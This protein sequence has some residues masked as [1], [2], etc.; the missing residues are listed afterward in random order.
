MRN[1][2]RFRNV[3]SGFVFYLHMTRQ[4]VADC[5]DSSPLT[6][7]YMIHELLATN[8]ESPTTGRLP[9]LSTFLGFRTGT[10]QHLQEVGGASAHA[11]VNVGFTGFDV[12]VEVVAESLDVRDDF[13]A[14]GGCEVAREEDW[15][16]MLARR[17]SWS[18]IGGRK[19]YQK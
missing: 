12:V 11:A 17:D 5:T 18:G 14:A 6:D 3:E 15:R 19:A 16:G 10:T 13:F 9:F 1:R 8:L 7:P 2:H 4:G